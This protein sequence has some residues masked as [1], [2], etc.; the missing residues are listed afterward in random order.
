MR[1]CVWVWAGLG[2]PAKRAHAQAL[3]AVVVDVVIET[4]KEQ[5]A[6]GGQAQAQTS[7]DAGLAGAR[8][9]GVGV[10]AEVGDVVGDVVE[11]GED[12]VV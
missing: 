2:D 12:G 8:R 10:L 4:S 1:V 7:A 3:R 5:R 11:G 6:Q 9:R